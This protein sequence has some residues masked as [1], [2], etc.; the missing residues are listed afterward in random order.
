VEREGGTDYVLNWVRTG[1]ADTFDAAANLAPMPAPVTATPVA[2]APRALPQGLKFSGIMAIG[3][4]RRAVI[5][6]VAFVT[7]DQK[8]IKLRDKSVLIRCREIRD[9]EVVIEATGAA[10]P[11]TLE[12]G[13]E[14]IL[15]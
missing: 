5:N 3:K 14:K 1:T 11:L 10:E 7:G 15:P 4:E 13:E 8:N 12:K 2:T 6:G 9:A